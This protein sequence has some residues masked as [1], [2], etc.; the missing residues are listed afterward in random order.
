ML[1]QRMTQAAETGGAA[2]EKFAA[3]GIS[4]AQINDPTFDLIE[5]MARLGASSNSTQELIA[6]LGARSAIRE[7]AEHHDLVAASAAKVNALMPQ[8]IAALT[9]YHAVTSTAET[10]LANLASRIAGAVAPALEQLLNIVKQLASDTTG[11]FTEVWDGIVAVL[12]AAA[13]NAVMLA[14]GFKALFDGLLNGIA[15]AVGPIAGFAAAI[16]ALAH[17]D[18]QGAKTIIVSAFNDIGANM[19][20]LAEDWK[21]D[22]EAGQLA[23]LQFRNTLDGEFRKPMPQISTDWFKAPLPD[24]SKPIVTMEELMSEAMDKVSQKVKDTLGKAWEEVANSAAASAKQQ[25]EAQVGAIDRQIQAVQALGNE[26]RISSSEELA[27]T[28]ALLNQKWGAQEAYYANLRALYADD[29]KELDTINKQEEADYQKHLTALQ[30][31]QDTATKEMDQQW[32]T[33]SNG[34][35]NALTTQI[36]KM[37]QHTESF[38]QAMRNMFAAMGEAIINTLIRVGGRC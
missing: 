36:D 1:T 2:A 12:K 34:I 14:E 18:V 4:V 19:D 16:N 26:H 38:T 24:L 27:D 22:S 23:V 17:G 21:K 8:E 20:K 37:L 11:H 29:P 7:L 25:E 6:A 30:K 3:L 28:T 10:Q 33:M 13:I 15:I 5:A 32:R 35:S 31:A 9:E